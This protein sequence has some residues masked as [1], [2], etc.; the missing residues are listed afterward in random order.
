MAY[1]GV[2]ILLIQDRGVWSYFRPDVNVYE[3]GQKAVIAYDHGVEILILA[4]DLYADAKTK[5]LEILPLPSAPK[6]DSS[7]IEIFHRIQ[8]KIQDFAFALAEKVSLTFDHS[9]GKGVEEIFHKRIGPHGLTVVRI[10][11]LND[12]RN[13][14]D[15]FLRREGV[16][17]RP[18]TEAL[19]GLVGV[20]LNDGINYFVFDVVEVDQ[21]PSTVF[22]LKFR[23]RSP[24]LYFP[25][26]ISRLAKGS[27][28]VQLFLLTH[29]IP[30]RFRQYPLR[31]GMTAIGIPIEARLTAKELYQIDPDFAHLLSRG[32]YLTALHY[33]GPVSELIRD[34]KV[35]R[36][37]RLVK[38]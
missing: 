35:R 11:D 16:K 13:W 24:C 14:I 29:L 38:E 37:Y 12:F 23:F 32:A 8:E 31:P 18:D 6:I 17:K 20:Y 30:D 7:D 25:L 10:R 19:E 3:P 22:P 1:L 34:L 27:T 4:N 2:L 9:R 21:D 5:V 15:E 26:Q 33:D 28:K 36:Y